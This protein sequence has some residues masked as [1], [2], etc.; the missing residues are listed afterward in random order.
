LKTEDGY[1][2]GSSEHL[3]KRA[4]QAGLMYGQDYPIFN[5][6]GSY[7][8]DPETDEPYQVRSG[9]FNELTEIGGSIL[10]GLG[11]SKLGKV[12]KK[13]YVKNIEPR[14]DPAGALT[15]AINL[16][17]PDADFNQNYLRAR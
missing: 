5:E 2:I 15:R 10:G 7:A 4:Q 14:V 16:D 1:P 6:D 12:A 13:G 9:R 8:I 11:L 3:I 17:Y